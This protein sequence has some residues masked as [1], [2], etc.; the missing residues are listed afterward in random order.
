MLINKKTKYILMAA[1]TILG[2]VAYIGLA[3]AVQGEPGSS[4]DPLVTKSFV[5]KYVD[6]KLK[7]Q[8]QAGGTG[9]RV[10]T[11]QV[12]QTFVGHGGTEFVLR[13]GKAVAVDPSTSGILNM[14]SGGNVL[15]NQAIPANNLLLVPRSDGRGFKASTQVIIMCNGGADIQ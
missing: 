15:A 1:I 14:T 11:V 6:G 10:V 13:S 9:W 12:G 8:G 2:L 7:E 5:E 4:T 3:G